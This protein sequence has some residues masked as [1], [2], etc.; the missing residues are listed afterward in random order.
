MNKISNNNLV[1]HIILM[2]NM[3][4]LNNKDNKV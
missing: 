3:K 4:K 1:K 2:I